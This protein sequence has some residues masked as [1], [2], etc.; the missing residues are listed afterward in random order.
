MPK[1]QILAEDRQMD[2]D[3]CGLV[4]SVPERVSGAP[5]LVGTRMPVQTI[6]DN[7]DAGMSPDEIAEQWELKLSDVNALLEYREK[8]SAC[9]SR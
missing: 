7:Y 8:L 2:W 4:E 5:V 1:K 9:P 6:V 3:G